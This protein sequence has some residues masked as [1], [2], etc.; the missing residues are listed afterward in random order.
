MNRIAA[1]QKAV[2]QVT[3][4]LGGDVTIRYVTAG[5]YDAATGLV[6]ETT[7]DVATKGILE[8]ISAREVNGLIETSDKR[9]TVAAKDLTTTP[10]T[11]DRVVI[12]SVV[13]QIINVNT[14]EQENSPLIYELV[15]RS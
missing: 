15:L 3:N 7:S 2:S 10:K 9:L 4:E 12:N 14:Q 5:N 13:H 11:K 6:A 1:L 8:N